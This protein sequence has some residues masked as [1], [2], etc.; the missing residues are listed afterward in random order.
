METYLTALITP[1]STAIVVSILNYFLEKRLKRKILYLQTALPKQIETAQQIFIKCQA[2]L[3]EVNEFSNDKKYS[4]LHTNLEPEHKVKYLCR[5]FEDFYR[6]FKQN[7]L[8][9]SKKLC[10]N[11]DDLS[12]Q[13][14]SFIDKYSSGIMPEIPD[15]GNEEDE[16]E[17]ASA[18]KVSAIWDINKFSDIL[19][20]IQ[21]TSKKIESQFRKI[22]GTK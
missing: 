7:N 12:K 2:F 16:D 5:L 20:E 11:M 17:P 4:D 21:K 19:P 1:V 10:K 18:V 8:L 22:Y 3:S 13:M 9:F 14:T 15:E 6:L